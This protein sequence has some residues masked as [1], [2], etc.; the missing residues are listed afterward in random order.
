MIIFENIHKE[1]SDYEDNYYAIESIFFDSVLEADSVNKLSSTDEIS[2]GRKLKEKIDKLIKELLSIIERAFLKISNMIKNFLQTDEGFKKSCRTQMTKVKP[3]EAVKL[4]AYDYDDGFLESQLNLL[5][6]VVSNS[7]NKIDTSQSENET[8][9][10][11]SANELIS[12]VLTKISSD[13]SVTNINLYFEFIKDKYRH[14]KSEQLFKASASREYY[15]KATGINST[16]SLVDAKQR[17]MIQQVGRIKHVLNQTS[18]NM[19][20]D[21][22]NLSLKQDLIKQ[23]ANATHLFNLYTSILNMYTQLKIEMHMQ[24]RAV[25]KKLYQF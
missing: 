19:G 11:L 6:Q 24:Y 10:R 15:T 1:I 9:M 20:T 23:N 12:N 3:L 21:K 17:T 2:I 8:D 16:K 22:S 13:N 25:M 7:L 14:S 4:I 18:K 5:T